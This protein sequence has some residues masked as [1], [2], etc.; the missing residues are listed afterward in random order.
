MKKEIS[1]I[2]LYDIM[3]NH[4]DPNGW[5]V[6]RSDWEI[7]WGAILIQNT[8][9]KNVAKANISLFK[10]TQFLPQKILA[11]SDEELIETIKSAGSYTRKAKTIKNLANFFNTYDFDLE[12]VTCLPKKDL[13]KKMLKISGIGPETADVILMYALQ[14]GEFVVDTYCRRLFNC[15]GVDL[16]A[17]NKAK[18]LI[19]IRLDNFTLR[20][21]QNFHAMIVLFNQD[22]K[23]PTQF[24]KSFL[25]PYK[26]IIAK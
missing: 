6:A 26:L 12:K 14:K 22:Y 13:R 9:W 3:Y 23:L 11:L 10:K 2:E 18:D 16:P 8:N 17:Y 19:E 15:L 21:Y 4:I 1:L 25:A 5:W 24:E 7:M 20:H